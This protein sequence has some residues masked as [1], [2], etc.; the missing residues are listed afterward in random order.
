MFVS[1]FVIC[2]V[3]VGMV[4]VVVNGPAVVV[5]DAFPRGGVIVGDPGFTN[6]N[7]VVVKVG[8]I[9]CGL[10]VV[11]VGSNTNGGAASF[12]CE[13]AFDDA[14]VFLLSGIAV[15]TDGWVEA[16]DAKVS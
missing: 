2:V 4:G 1:L 6:E 11:D 7:G 14:V 5:K 9:M 12:L 3:V 13:D 16:K 15:C 10:H 8:G